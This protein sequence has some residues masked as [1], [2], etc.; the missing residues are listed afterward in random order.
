MRFVVASDDR[1]QSAAPP[2]AARIRNHF[3]RDISRLT[4]G[5]VQGR[6]DGFYIGPAPLITLGPPESANGT[7]VRWPITGGLLTR[8]PGGEVGFEWEDGR[9]RGYVTG[10]APSLP[11]WLYGV[12][13]RL[14][15][16]EITR[17]YLLRTRGRDPLPSPPPPANRRLAAVAIDLGLCWFVAQGR[18]R[19]FAGVAAGYHIAAWTLAG[20]TLGGALLDQRLISVDGSPVTIGQAL[21]R[22]L[23]VPVGRARQDE[24]AGTAVIDARPP[25]D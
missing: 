24:V 12:T 20:R 17:L 10:Y 4:L 14:V 13:Q 6:T 11:R 21:A 25:R 3:T 1:V 7:G 23:L 2:N 15:H 8:R 16:R 9:L 22:L 5:I 18:L 19:R